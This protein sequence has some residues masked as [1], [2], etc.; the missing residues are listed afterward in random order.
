MDANG[1]NPPAGSEAVDHDDCMI[2]LMCFDPFTANELRS[3]PAA[4]RYVADEFPGYPCRQC[5]RDAQVGEELLLVSHDPFKKSSPYRQRS[6]IFLHILDCSTNRDESPYPEQ[7]RRRQ[8]S[9]RSFD[10]EQMMIDAEVIQGGELEAT[11]AKFAAVTETSFIDVHNAT[12]GCW[13]AR[14]AESAARPSK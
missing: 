8:L 11:I 7:L 1:R 10:E 6:P 14:F 2:S 3:D 4:T 12:R 13:A 5:L 9:I